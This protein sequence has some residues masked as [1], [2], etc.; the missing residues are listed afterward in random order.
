MDYSSAISLHRLAPRL[1]FIDDLS[2]VLAL[3]FGAAATLTATVWGSIRLILDQGS[4]AGET[5]K[6]MLDMFEEL[7]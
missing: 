7:S 1:T 2:A 6:D 4:S 5:L 3:C